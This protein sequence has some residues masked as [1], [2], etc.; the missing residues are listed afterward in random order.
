MSNLEQPQLKNEEEEA[1]GVEGVN[2]QQQSSL[3][4]PTFSG[5]L[6]R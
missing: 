4:L 5:V 2:E 6:K 3:K 1:L